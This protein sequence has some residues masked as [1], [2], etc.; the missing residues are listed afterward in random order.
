LHPQINSGSSIIRIPPEEFEIYGTFY[1]P[2][3]NALLIVNES[4]AF[5]NCGKYNDYLSGCDFPLK[6]LCFEFLANCLCSTFLSRDFDPS[7]SYSWIDSLVLILLLQHL[8]AVVLG[9]LN[10]QCRKRLISKMTG[11]LFNTMSK[12]YSLS[13]NLFVMWK[14]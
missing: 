12:N 1:I 4:Q 5:V 10:C 3:C 7:Y 6:F 13:S 8:K 11:H 2:H 14:I 9:F